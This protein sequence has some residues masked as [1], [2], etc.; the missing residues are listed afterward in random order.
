MAGFIGFREGFLMFS[1]SVIGS[2]VGVFVIK[3]ITDHYKRASLI[4][5]LLGGLIILVSV[6]IPISLVFMIIQQVND[7][8]F[9]FTLS[10][11][12]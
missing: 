2:C 4:V 9:S 8:T 1:V 3:K 5:F 11:I 7:G 12:C 6:M 10:S